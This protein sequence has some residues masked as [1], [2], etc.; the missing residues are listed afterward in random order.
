MSAKKS[1][2]RPSVSEA[3]LLAAIERAQLHSRRE[4]SGVRLATIAEHLG[5]APGSWTTRRLRPQLETL[6]AADLIVSSRRHGAVVWASP[7]PAA[8]VSPQ[9]VALAR[10]NGCRSHPSTGFGVKRAPK[11]PSGSG[12]SAS[13]SGTR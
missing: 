9:S 5:F 4:A 11:R 2:P 3:L 10:S 13:N 7:I 6:A 1:A 12:T 8:S